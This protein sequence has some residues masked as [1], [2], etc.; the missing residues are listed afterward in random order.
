MNKFLSSFLIVLFSSI[1]LSGLTQDKYYVF[2]KDKNNVE[3]NPYSYF[4]SKAIERRVR[5]NVEI[6]N[7]TDYPLRS[8]YVDEITFLVSHAGFQSRWFNMIVVKAYQNEIEIVRQLEFVREVVKAPNQILIVA[9]NNIGES[10]LI[11]SD[12]LSQQVESLGGSVFK[13]AG[14]NGKGV[15]IAIFDVGFKNVD[16]HIAFEQIRNENRIVK[17]WDFVKDEEFVYDFGTH[18]RSVFSCVAGIYEGNNIG[19]ATAAEF[20]LARTEYGLKEPFSEEE[21]WLAAAEWADKNGADII[22][23]S[24]GY[25]HHRYFPTDM[26]G[27]TSLVARA[28]T[29]AARKGILVVN[30]MGNAGSGKWK[31]LGTPADADSILS[32]GGIAPNT[33]IHTSFSS[34]GPTTDNRMKPNITAYGHVM[35]AGK[36]E[37]SETQGTSFSSPL[38]AGFA[39]CIL[40]LNP[41]YTNMQLI[42]AIEKSGNLYPY[43]DYAHGYGVPQAKYFIGDKIKQPKTLDF[44]LQGDSLTVQVD[45]SFIDDNK[46]NYLYYHIENTDGVLKKYAVIKTYQANVISF[47][48]NDFTKGQILRVHFKNYTSEYKF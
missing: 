22:N 11:K 43:Y 26:D 9:G 24:L 23:S 12:L 5:N 45:T 21:N 31:I 37:L 20:M 1:A 33:G 30:A 17:T 2:L 19:L 16:T 35:A 48:I 3:F 32:V 18:G 7:I 38:L 44:T 10:E 29:M 27:K 46:H 13:S 4:D 40:Q 15:R 42:N 41:N 34:F 25:T 28:A 47:K 36:E 8:D 6:N 14:I 39:A